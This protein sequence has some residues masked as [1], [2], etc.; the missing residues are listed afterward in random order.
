LCTIIICTNLLWVLFMFSLLKLYFS[1]YYFVHHWFVNCIVRPSI[2]RVLIP[3]WYL[4]T[5]G[6]TIVFYQICIGAKEN[7]K[8]GEGNQE[9]TRKCYKIILFPCHLTNI[10]NK[11]NMINKIL[12]DTLTWWFWHSYL[13]ILSV[14]IKFVKLAK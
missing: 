13:V 3:T 1:F 8:K 6:L 9:W 4:Q 14:L 7:R 5:V 12:S 2:Y 10:S 11:F